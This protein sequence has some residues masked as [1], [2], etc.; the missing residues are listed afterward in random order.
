EEILDELEILKLVEHDPKAERLIKG[1]ES[2]FKREKDRKV[3]VFSE[4]ID[5]VKYL[6]P[7]LKEKFNNRVLVIAGDLTKSKTREIYTNFD[8]SYPEEKQADDYD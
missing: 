5:T 4:Y 6:E 3:V 1:I 7:I 2:S 8:A